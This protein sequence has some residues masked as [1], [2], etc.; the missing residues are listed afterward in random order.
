MIASPFRYLLALKAPI[1]DSLGQRPQDFKLHSRASAFLVS[2][3]P[4][5]LP[6]ARDEWC[7]FG[8]KRV[9]PTWERRNKLRRTQQEF[10]ARADASHYTP[11]R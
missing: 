8:A 4:G 5:A 9:A 7:A 6:Q 1:H 11:L 2:A 10:F 3:N